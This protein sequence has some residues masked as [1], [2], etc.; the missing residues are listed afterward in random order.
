MRFL[1]N[2]HRRDAEIAEIAQRK[3]KTEHN[4]SLIPGDN[5]TITASS[6]IRK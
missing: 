4:L 6:N 3:P 2:I 1:N 5:D